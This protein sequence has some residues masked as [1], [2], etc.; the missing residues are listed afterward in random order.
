MKFMG[1]FLGSFSFLIL[2]QTG[3]NIDS[4]WSL[5]YCFLLSVAVVRT[6]N[7]NDVYVSFLTPYPSKQ[8]AH[9]IFSKN[10]S[11]SHLIQANREH[12]IFDLVFD[13]IFDSGSNDSTPIPH[14]YKSESTQLRTQSFSIRLDGK[15]RVGTPLRRN[16]VQSQ[17]RT[18][19]G[20]YLICRTNFQ[21]FWAPEFVKVCSFSKDQY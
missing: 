15:C 19:I 17:K 18:N 12:T 2:P 1:Y 13:S 21:T 20:R 4:A 5:Y 6:G 14:F 9:L 16:L 3:N 11:S 8:R 7:K 10:V